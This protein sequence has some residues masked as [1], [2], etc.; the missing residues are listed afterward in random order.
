M[1]FGTPPNKG[2]QEGFLT[3]LLKIS[4]SKSESLLRKN[5]NNFFEVFISIRSMQ[6]LKHLANRSRQVRKNLLQIT[7]P[8]SK[9]FFCQILQRTCRL[10][11]WHP[12]EKPFFIA[13]RICRHFP[14]TS[15]TIFLFGRLQCRF[16]NLP[17]NSFQTPLFV[18]KKY[19]RMCFRTCILQF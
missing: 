12:F 9:F 19:S 10:E 11:L 18:E 7:E 6:F 14:R 8:L 5:K 3:N 17:E 16:H 4:C 13:R 15:S 1:S 2:T